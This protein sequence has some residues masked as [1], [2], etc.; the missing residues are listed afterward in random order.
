MPRGPLPKKD[1]RR[2]NAPT[3]PT[4]DL[5]AAGNTGKRPTCPYKLGPAGKAWWNWAWKTPQA[6]AWDHGARYFVARRAQL[7]DM[8]AA[9]DAA[10]DSAA[11]AELFHLDEHSDFTEQLR[12]VLGG[13]KRAAGGLV[14]IAREMR[15]LEN[16]LGLN[17]KALAENRWT[18][19]ASAQPEPEVA[20]PD[21]GS[22]PDERR[23][24]MRI[25]DPAAVGQ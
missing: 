5:P 1:A 23:R 2:R 20:A 18:I 10:E 16:R 13:L 12:W 7:E 22:T 14:P 21:P 11:I 6:A 24:S 8:A 9:L 19:I 25:V 17:P 15:E 4:T 3:I